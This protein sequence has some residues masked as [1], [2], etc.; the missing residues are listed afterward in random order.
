MTLEQWL[1]NSWL[2]GIEANAHETQNLLA[3]AEREIADA[4]IE[5][6]SDDGRFTHAY[7]AVRALC[8]VALFASGYSIPKGQRQ[9]E[10]L[11][12]SL[13]FT[14]GESWS[15]DVDYF[16]RCRRLRH[17]SLYD[18]TGMASPADA[19]EL[20]QSARKLLTAVRSWLIEHHPR[21]LNDPSP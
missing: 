9:H 21:L 10:R 4:S 8:E 18:G 11:I 1:S 15:E 2:I 12:A 7:S 5:Q 19:R 14:L 17:K 6:I 3:I 16:D 20:L 13:K